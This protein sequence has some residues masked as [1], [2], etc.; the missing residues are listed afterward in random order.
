MRFILATEGSGMPLVL[1]GPEGAE[2]GAEL[3]YLPSVLRPV[4]SS[5][6]GDRPIVGRLRL[7]KQLADRA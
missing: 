6:S 1:T 5:L 2:R 3:V 4:P 7:A